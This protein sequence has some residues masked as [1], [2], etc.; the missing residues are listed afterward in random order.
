MRASVE[1]KLAHIRV[2]SYSQV[3]IYNSFT[4]N[5]YL[6]DGVGE[7]YT[8]SLLTTNGTEGFIK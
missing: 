8:L 3:K 5:K 4:S 1:T 6:K 7:W 2:R